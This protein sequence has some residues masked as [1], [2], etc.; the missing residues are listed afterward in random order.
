[1]IHIK[2]ESNIE[3]ILVLL[4]F[5]NSFF[6]ASVIASE[7]DVNNA[8]LAAL[9]DNVL[10]LL[11]VPIEFSEDSE[12]VCED[13]NLIEVADGHLVKLFAI[14]LLVHAV[15]IVYDTLGGVLLNDTNG[16]ITDSGLTLLG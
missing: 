14:S 7:L 15:G 11:H 12:N 3:D 13:T 5:S 4:D 16:L 9:K 1:M 6:Y 2:S 10:K 8:R